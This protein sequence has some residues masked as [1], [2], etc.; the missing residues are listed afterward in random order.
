M[1]GWQAGVSGLVFLTSFVAGSLELAAVVSA[2]SGLCLGQPLTVGESYRLALGRFWAI[3][4]ISLLL[5]GLV[6]ALIMIWMVPAFLSPA[7]IC[8]TT[9]LVGGV[10]VYLVVRWSVAIPALVI[11]RLGAVAA[12]GRSRALVR[13]AW[14]RT[15]LT[16]VLLAILLAVLWVMGY[17]LVS[18]L[19]G[20][21]QA[22]LAPGVRGQTDWA[23]VVESL[24]NSAVGLAFGPLFHIG[25]TLMYYDRRVRVEAY[26]ISL[27]AQNMLRQQGPEPAPS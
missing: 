17:A 8:V 10:A 27:L 24:L 13:G 7:L 14:W 2:T 5:L 1:E 6:A 11:E 26:D 3:I 23:A 22:V 20:T 25:L 4:R 16:L 19:V 12:L 9:P 15:C 18:A 21:L